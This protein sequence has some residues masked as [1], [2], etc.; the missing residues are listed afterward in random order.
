MAGI[1]SNEFLASLNVKAVPPRTVRKKKAEIPAQ[2]IE[3]VA[4]EKSLSETTA[5]F[6]APDIL[7]KTPEPA[8]QETSGEKRIRTAAYIRVSTDSEAQEDSYE[9]QERY[10]ARLLDNHPEW[11]NAGIYS[12]FGIS[13][14]QKDTRTGFTRLIRHCE[15]SRIDKIVCK[16]ISRFSRNTLQCLETLRHLKELGVFVTFEK[17][18]LDTGDTVSEFILTTLTAIAQEESR[19]ISTNIR[20]G[21]E[22]RNP[23]GEVA[24]QDI[25]GY[26][27]T[28][29]WQTMESGYKLRELEIVEEEAEVVR[30]IFAMF[31]DG[32]GATEI[33]R[34]LNR[35]NVPPPKALLFKTPQRRSVK[36]GIEQ[37]WT[38]SRIRG[39][40]DQ[41]RYCGDVLTQKVI[42]D[43]YLTH[44]Q[45]VNK[46]G[47][48]Q[49]YIKDHH[50]AI[51]S[52]EEYEQVKAIRQPGT[53]KSKG[54]SFHA[55]SGRLICPRCGR[56]FYVTN[57][58]VHPIWRCPSSASTVKH[59][60]DAEKV[61]EEQIVRM[62]RKAFLERFQLAPAAIPKDTDLFLGRF[63]V[64]VSFTQ[65]ADSFV[66]Q[67][68]GRLESIQEFDHVESDRHLKLK[69]INAL[70]K[71]IDAE[72]KAKE[73]AQAELEALKI[74][75]E[76]FA[77]DAD[78]S[79]EKAIRKQIK[80]ADEMIRKATAEKKEKE[81]E[82]DALEK[83]W[84]QQEAD[85][86]LRDKAIAWMKGLPEGREGT[87][88][89]LNGLTDT[90]V[91]A[92]AMSITIHDPLHYT[93]QWFDGTESDVEMYSNIEGWQYTSDYWDGTK[94]ARKK[95]RRK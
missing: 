36:K 63:T 61:Y 8:R 16:S 83:V 84:Q 62:F 18:G 65:A 1:S 77:E 30:R 5:S 24:N 76:V 54:R 19:S 74:R 12:D 69:Y 22:K 75:W 59:I 56:F 39:I 68:I 66:Q 23:K 60:C 42:T 4:D 26:R 71:E 3:A 80:D 45:R 55:F 51:V 34:K 40:L 67:M 81:A 93:V 17:E 64:A 73:R 37:G 31:L 47:I 50:P 49:Y 87:V 43:D 78:R 72:K 79:R 48:G 52:R 91:G 35:E 46:E 14:T 86:V 53:R 89:F 28:G 2:E 44:K 25:Y 70:A 41:E 38:A 11:K 20:W 57:A 7:S 10:F 58:Q 21:I 33:A 9:A 90:Y 88:Q 27:F 94:M 13:G 92:F 95:G 82:L 15:Q 85:Y 6:F 32:L 29:E